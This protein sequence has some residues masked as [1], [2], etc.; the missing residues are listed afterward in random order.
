MGLWV[1]VVEGRDGGEVIGVMK[2][3]WMVEGRV[4]ARGSYGMER[5]NDGGGGGG[6]G[7]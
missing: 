5:G 6:G 1:M 3:G 7:R 4:G 2:W